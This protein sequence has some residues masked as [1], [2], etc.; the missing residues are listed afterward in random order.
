M[1]YRMEPCGNRGVP[2]SYR[3]VDNTRSPVGTAMC[4]ATFDDAKA[5]VTALNLV[6]DLETAP[7]DDA[8]KDG[9][10]RMREMAAH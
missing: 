10:R 1:R 7:V 8:V 4:E 5:I 9:I 3:I 6:H 2:A